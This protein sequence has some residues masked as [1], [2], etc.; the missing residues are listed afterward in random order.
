MEEESSTYSNRTKIDPDG[1]L[2]LVLR[3]QELLVSRKV[4][5]LSSS[6]FRAMLRD[7]SAFAE[8][9][10]RVIAS[11]GFQHID[12]EDDDCEAMTIVANVIHLQHDLIPEKVSFG[13]LG[14]LAEVCDKYDLR[15]SFGFWPQK[16]SEIHLQSDSRRWL[17]ISLV[18]RIP[19]V[20]LLV[21]KRIILSV[22]LSEDGDL[23]A[24][25]FARIT[26]GVPDVLLGIHL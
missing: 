4:L 21:S 23:D 19:T 25:G 9:S 22:N 2:V 8:S 20:F 3:E 26:E 24:P 10:N 1:D 11:D 15:K 14:R 7:G 17:F 18:F 5:C 16:W 12:L 13:L 6:V